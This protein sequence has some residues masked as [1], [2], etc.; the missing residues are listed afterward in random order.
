MKPQDQVDG[1]MVNFSKHSEE[2]IIFCC[3]D[4]QKYLRKVN[5]ISNCQRL[6]VFPILRKE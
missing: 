6:N 1:K 5:L 3:N 2:T 4:C